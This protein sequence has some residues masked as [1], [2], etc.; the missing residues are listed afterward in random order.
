MKCGAYTLFCHVSC[1]SLSAKET[2]IIGLSSRKWPVKIRHPLQVCY[3]VLISVCVALLQWDTN[4][5]WSRYTFELAQTL[6]FHGMCSQLQFAKFSFLDGLC[7]TN[8]LL[9]DLLLNCLVLSLLLFFSS[10]PPFMRSTLF[11]LLVSVRSLSLLYPSHIHLILPIN[12]PPTDFPQHMYA[13]S[14]IFCDQNVF[15]I[16]QGAFQKW[17]SPSSDRASY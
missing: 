13:Y 11:A 10:I 5:P 14:A 8:L 9:V 16:S 6:L 12:L 4:H 2:L 15:R 1:R 7:R 17:S 3:P